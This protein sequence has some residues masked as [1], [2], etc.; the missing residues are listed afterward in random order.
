[1]VHDEIDQHADATLLAAVGE[2]DEIPKR[3][4][5]RIDAVV[6]GDVIAVVTHRRGLE[7]H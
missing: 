3:A 1:M 4:V 6:V 2:F 5:T 7:R